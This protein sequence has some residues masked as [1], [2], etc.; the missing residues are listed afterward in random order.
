M[1][2]SGALRPMIPALSALVAELNLSDTQKVC[3]TKVAM[4]ETY[5]RGNIDC[6]A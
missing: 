4:Y 3:H 2:F 6:S 5:T 1:K